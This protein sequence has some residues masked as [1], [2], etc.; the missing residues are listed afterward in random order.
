[1]DWEHN[2]LVVEN[3]LGR[4]A[5]PSASISALLLGPGTR[6]THAAVSLLAECGASVVWCGQGVVRCYASGLGD[7]RRAD[8]LMHHARV[9]ADESARFEAVMRMYRH[10]FSEELDPG[11]SLEQVRGKEGVRVRE[12]YARIGRET[13]IEWKGRSYK[14]DSWD[15]ADPVNRALSAANSCLYALCHAGIVATGFSPSLGFVHTGKALSFVYDVADLYKCDVTVPLAFRAV[16]LGTEGLDGRVRRLCR[17]AF[18]RDCLLERIVPDIQRVLG[19]R[20]EVVRAARLY[21]EDEVARIRD[22]K[23]GAL[24]GGRN[25]ADGD[26]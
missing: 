26:A 4:T 15:S 3:E 23:A 18:F 7:T 19:L 2:G 17:D 22:P 1:M 13:G 24:E 12:A 5:V 25:F 14:R 21:E 6:V 20:P 10:R 16:T 11:L 9:W 8:N